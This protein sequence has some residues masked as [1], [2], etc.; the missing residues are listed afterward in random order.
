MPRNFLLLL[1]LLTAICS[2]GQTTCP[3]VNFLTGQTV[4]LQPTP[5]SHLDLLRQSDGSYT[6]FEVPNTSPSLVVSTTPHFEKQIVGCLPAGLLN[7]NAKSAEPSINQSLKSSYYSVFGLIA[8]GKYLQ[9][10][11]VGNVGTIQFNLFDSQHHLLSTNTFTPPVLTAGATSSETF[12]QFLLADVTGDGKADLLVSS[13]TN[14]IGS[15]FETAIWVFPGRGDGSFGT[16]VRQAFPGADPTFPFSVADVNGDRIPDVISTDATFQN[17]IVDYGLGGNQF[18]PHTIPLPVKFSYIGGLTIADLNGD[19]RADLIVSGITDNSPAVIV[20]LAN[21]GG[22]FNSPQIYAPVYPY[23]FSFPSDVTIGDVN[24]DSIPD[25]VLATGTILFGD[26]KGGFPQ[27]NQYALDS[28]SAVV[29]T[30]IDGDGIA[31]LVFGRGTADVLFGSSLTVM[32]GSG[33]GRF[34]GPMSSDPAL[35]PDLSN[36]SFQFVVA[37]FDGDGASETVVMY[38]QPDAIYWTALKL[39]ADRRFLS[40][41]QEKLAHAAK[42]TAASI[43]A[44]DFDQDGKKDIALLLQLAGGGSEIQF[45]RGRGDG[46]FEVPVTTPLSENAEFITTADVN[47]D[48]IPDLVGTAGDSVWVRLGRGNGTF[49]PVTFSV[50]VS[51]PAIAVGDFN[52]DGK[53][54]LLITATGTNSPL[55][56]L[57]GKGNGEFGTA[58]K[59]TIPGYFYR[60][61]YGLTVADLNLDGFLDVILPVDQ[62][63]V[64]MIG[65]ADGTFQAHSLPVYGAP[66]VL[67]IDVADLN[68]DQVPDLI[69]NVPYRG[70]PRPFTIQVGSTDGTFG[71]VIAGPPNARL[72]YGDLNGDGLIDLIEVT[73]QGVAAFLNISQVAPPLTVVSAATFRAGPIAP[74]SLV[75]GFGLRLASA[76]FTAVPAASPLGEV[77]VSVQDSA[78]VV[79]PAPMTFVS[80]GQV[81]FLVP[82]D[83]S[84]GTAKI[85]VKN[86]PLGAPVSAQATVNPLAPGLFTQAVVSLSGGP[87]AVPAGYAIRVDASG[88][89]T[90]L[91]LA[92]EAPGAPA[93]ANLPLLNSPIDLTLPG[94]VYLALFGTGFDATDADSTM[95]TVQGLP[96]PVTFAG[97]VPGVPGLDQVNLLLPPSLAGTGTAFVSITVRGV[98]MNEVTVSIR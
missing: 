96:V 54:D 12:Q 24:G 90:I 50:E 67:S 66:E 6:A 32:I 3:A 53:P 25:I 83:T 68:A 33:D 30:D 98:L 65:Q 87:A 39:S 75:A 41:G 79:R 31:D 47:G 44:A 49:G 21:A 8:P 88:I 91:P 28:N 82:S 51:S 26:G 84:Y 81:N 92:A 55:T 64:A 56:V 18:D 77:T 73:S 7:N 60:K 42:S 86:G 45:Y 17:M 72:A 43:A 89:Q 76:T 23:I 74:G 14:L 57:P 27:R 71:P 22:G 35:T 58:I 78:G 29:I 40:L 13:L 16:G 4:N 46:R 37:D 38:S 11:V 95:A 10:G 93:G 9:A 5:S 94:K 59:S 2:F 97:P 1:L 20:V 69:A 36:S 15:K 70:A 62:A 63:S 48:A 85:T 52:H 80:M 19:G 34:L 61:A